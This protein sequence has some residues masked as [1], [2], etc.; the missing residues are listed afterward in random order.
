MAHK[1]VS[2][3]AVL[4]L[5]LTGCSEPEPIEI[6]PAPILVPLSELSEG[7][8]A[9]RDLSPEILDAP[10]TFD[11]ESDKRLF[12]VVVSCSD[13]N[14]TGIGILPFSGLTT[15][16]LTRAQAHEYDRYIY[17]CGQ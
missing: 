17:E 11:V 7:I 13:E 14:Q 5:A 2:I 3:T 12:M 4:L 1:A 9:I 16:I 15:D 8:F 6:D 10:A